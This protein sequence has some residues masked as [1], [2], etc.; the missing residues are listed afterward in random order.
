MKAGYNIVNSISS[1][2]T[3]IEVINHQDSNDII[4]LGWM[5]LRTAYIYKSKATVG[6]WKP[7]QL[8]N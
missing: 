2:N 5:Y 1:G 6:V 8:K 7:K 3:V 4:N